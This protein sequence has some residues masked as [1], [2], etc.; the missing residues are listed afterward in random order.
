MAVAPARPDNPIIGNAHAADT[1]VGSGIYN[2]NCACLRHRVAAEEGN[3][4]ELERSALHRFHPPK[5]IACQR[6]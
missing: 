6:I 4:Q 3:Q 1:T 5:N 2:G